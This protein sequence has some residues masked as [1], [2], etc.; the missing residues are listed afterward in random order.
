MSLI[1][2]K[3]CNNE[4]KRPHRPLSLLCGDTL[5]SKCVETLQNQN[6][7]PSKKYKTRIKCPFYQKV[8]NYKNFSDIKINIEEEN[9]AYHNHT[10]S[11]SSEEEDPNYLYTIEEENDTFKESKKSKKQKVCKEM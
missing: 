11:E 6:L 8:S 2:C 4:Y 3:K 10:D 5:C 9:K 7:K 1:S